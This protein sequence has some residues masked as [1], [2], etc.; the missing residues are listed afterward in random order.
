MSK[1]LSAVL[2]AATLLAGDISSAQNPTYDIGPVWRMVY[3]RSKP[4]QDELF[5]KNINQNLKPGLIEAQKQGEILESR[6]FTNPLP[7]E[8]GDWQMLLMLKYPNYAALDGLAA[9]S[10]AVY[11]KVYATPAAA[12]EAAKMRADSTETLSVHLLR[13]ILE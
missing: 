1:V 4:G 13:Q 12:A 2:I 9:K 10:A 7:T 3:Y 8:P 6:I 5:W 11:A